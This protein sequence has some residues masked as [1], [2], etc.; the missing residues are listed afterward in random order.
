MLIVRSGARPDFIKNLPRPTAAEIKKQ[1]TTDCPVCLQSL[2]SIETEEEYALADEAFFGD[3]EALGLRK[4]P[5]DGGH[6][7]CARCCKSWLRLVGFPSPLSIAW[8]APMQADARTTRA[9]CAA[10]SSIRRPPSATR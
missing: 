3:L 10:P 2:A 6:V 5:C 1:E 4:L 7:V 8:D 9:P